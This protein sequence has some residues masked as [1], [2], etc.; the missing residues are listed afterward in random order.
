VFKTRQKR[1]GTTAKAMPEKMTGRNPENETHNNKGRRIGE[2]NHGGSKNCQ[3]EG[4]HPLG[5]E[6][7]FHL[8]L[9]GK[10]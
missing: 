3:A 6:V 5:L 1:R 4:F 8:V 2:G 9:P 7:A 10:A